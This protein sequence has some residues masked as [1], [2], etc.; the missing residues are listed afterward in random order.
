MDA[1]HHHHHIAF[2]DRRST[3]E[4]HRQRN[5][6]RRQFNIFSRILSFSE[7]YWL[8]WLICVLQRSRWKWLTVA[9][10]TTAAVINCVLTVR[11]ALCARVMRATCSCQTPSH[12]KVI[13][14]THLY[15]IKCT[16]MNTTNRIHLKLS[17]NQTT[18][19]SDKIKQELSYR[20]QIVRQLHKH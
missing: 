8:F 2:V 15:I 17:Q 18:Q 3:T 12:V 6:M 4:L 19:S 7:R 20:K 1:H 10:W 14:Y 13:H 5:V 9:L 16:F 11:T